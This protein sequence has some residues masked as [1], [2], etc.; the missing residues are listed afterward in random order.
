MRVTQRSLQRN[1]MNGINRNLGNLSKSNDRLTTGRRFSRVSENV[2]DAA[3]A[4]RVRDKLNRNEQYIGN[5]DNLDVEL[6][7]QESGV[8]QINDI[9]TNVKELMIKASNDT[10][11]AEDRKII[12]RELENLRDGIVQIINTKS[13]DKYTFS[14]SDNKKPLEIID[15]KVYI[16]GQDVDAIENPEDIQKLLGG[17]V[18]VDIGVGLEV[19]GG[20]VDRTSAAQLTT[21]AGSVLGYGTTEDGMPKNIISLLNNVITDLNNDDTSNMGRYGE[22][23]DDAK[24]DL[25]VQA[26]DIGTRTKYVADTKNRLEMENISLTEQM[27]NL[28][29]V[30]IESEIIYNKSYEM[31]WQISLQLGSQILP[32]SIFDF[33]R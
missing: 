9:L 28:E 19:N 24:V 27:N 25:L 32:S 26:T 12:A 29:A 3:R 17:Q 23:V 20:S 21:A 14:G 16:N 2:T 18:F 31:T 6:S 8:M 15:G 5:L 30:D 4:L 33:M 13:T 22:L 11:S 7:A 10:N 1:Y